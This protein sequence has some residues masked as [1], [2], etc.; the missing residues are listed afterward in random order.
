MDSRSKSKNRKPTIIQLTKT[1][2]NKTKTKG[3]NGR[4]E[5]TN[6]KQNKQTNKF[7]VQQQ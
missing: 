4:D 3:I 1:K 2:Q 7:Q 5:Q 6:E